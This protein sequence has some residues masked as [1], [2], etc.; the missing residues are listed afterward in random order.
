MKGV[1]VVVIV[2]LIHPV[3]EP[4]AAAVH[5]LQPGEKLIHNRTVGG[6]TV[7]V[8]HEKFQDVDSHEIVVVVDDAVAARRAQP[9]G[10]EILF[11]LRER[12]PKLFRSELERDGQQANLDMMLMIVRVRPPIMLALGIGSDHQARAKPGGNFLAQSRIVGTR[13][14]LQ[15][16]RRQQQ[17]AGEGLQPVGLGIVIARRAFDV[18]VGLAR[19]HEGGERFEELPGG[20]LPMAVGFGNHDL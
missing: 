17:R 8:L 7:A 18:E 6:A 12:I 16:M 10:D 5:Q 3:L 2:G 19:L 14:G 13:H 11:V 4:A 20:L 9:A 1:G 15:P